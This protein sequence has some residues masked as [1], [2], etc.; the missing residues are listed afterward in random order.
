VGWW[1]REQSAAL[2]EDW[3]D[4]V[5]ARMPTWWDVPVE[6]RTAARDGAERF[7]GSVRWEAARGFELTDEVRVV[8]AS[9]AGLL[10]AGLELEGLLPDGLGNVGSV[11]VH[12]TTLVSTGERAGPVPGVMSD[13]DVVLA[14]E[15]AHGHGPVVL[16]WDELVRDLRHPRRGRNVAIHELAHKLDMLDEVV[17]GTPRFADRDQGARWVE[18]CTAAFHDLV[19][20]GSP[21]LDDYGTTDAGEFFAVAT[22][23]FFVRPIELRQHHPDLYEVFAAFYHLDP[24]AWPD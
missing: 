11:I 3:E 12:A 23:A 22:E 1:R 13:D 20:H 9:Q 10:L 16:A 15:A 6:V 2:P 17:D 18:V 5:A 8:V 14:G 19:E 7:G 24:A 4:V 21:V